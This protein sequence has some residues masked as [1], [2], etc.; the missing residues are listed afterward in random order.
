M[1]RPA[2]ANDIEAIV[3]LG[4]EFAIKSQPVHTMSVNVEKIKM[5]VTSAITSDDAILLV[6]DIDGK[7]EG[8][9]FGL[10]L[11]SYFSD[12]KIL[13]ELALYS[14]KNRGGL[15]LIDTFEKEARLRGIHKIIVGS[16]PDFYDLKKIYERKGYKLLETQYI[17]EI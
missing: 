5:V 17:K 8:I 9:I 11:P 13:Q 10:I 14:K 12:D 6:S 15:E 7:V 3:A 4:V 16:K 1:I 2:T